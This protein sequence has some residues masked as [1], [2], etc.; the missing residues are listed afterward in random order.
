LL[1]HGVSVL[2]IQKLLGHANLETTAIYLDMS[3]EHLRKAIKHLPDP[4]MHVEGKTVIYHQPMGEVIEGEVT[5]VYTPK[6]GDTRP[7]G[8]VRKRARLEYSLGVLREQK[9]QAA[10]KKKREYIVDYMFANFPT[11]EKLV[12]R[13]GMMKMK[14]DV[15]MKLLHDFSKNIK[16]LGREG[17]AFTINRLRSEWLDLFYEYDAL[18]TSMVKLEKGYPVRD[19]KERPMFAARK[20]TA[21]E[22]KLGI[23][24]SLPKNM[25]TT[26]LG[27]TNMPGMYKSWIL[28]NGDVA[29]V[30]KLGDPLHPVWAHMQ[31]AIMSGANVSKLFKDGLVK[32]NVFQRKG[33]EPISHNFE[34]V[35]QGVNSANLAT[36]KQ[37]MKQFTVEGRINVLTVTV[38]DRSGRIEYSS[39]DQIPKA[40]DQAIAMARKPSKL[41]P[42]INREAAKAWNK[43]IE[44]QN[45]RLKRQREKEDEAKDKD[46]R[47]LIKRLKKEEKKAA[48]AYKRGLIDAKRELVRMVASG[49]EWRKEFANYVQENLPPHVRGKLLKTIAGITS[50][51]TNLKAMGKVLKEIERLE[52]AEAKGR[53]KKW[54]A[55]FGKKYGYRQKQGYKKGMKFKIATPFSAAIE[56]ILDNMMLV[57]PRDPASLQEMLEYVLQEKAMAEEELKAQGREDEVSTHP[58]IRHEIDKSIETFERKLKSQKVAD[59]TA[60]EINQLLELLDTILGEHEYKRSQRAKDVQERRA[61]IKEASLEEVGSGHKKVIPEASTDKDFGK[62]RSRYRTKHFWLGLFGR[63]NYNISTL[64]K[65]MGGM[66]DGALYHTLV[67]QLQRG[68]DDE[69]SHVFM[70]M[71]EFQRLTK[72]AGITKKDL[73]RWSHYGNIRPSVFSRKIEAWLEKNVPGALEGKVEHVE[74]QDFAIQLESG[75]TLRLTVAE[76]LSLLMHVRNEFAYNQLKKNGI[77]TRR[78]PLKRLELKDDDF[79]TV[80]AVMPPKALQ[81]L[82]IMADLMDMQSDAINEVSLELVAGKQGE[83]L[84]PGPIKQTIESRSHLKERKGGTDPIYIDDAFNELVDATRV[85]AEYIGL[86]KPLEDIRWLTNDQDVVKALL[87]RGYGDYYRDYVMQ[88]DSIQEHPIGLDWWE[89]LYGSWVRN[90]TRAVFGLNLRVSAQQY[91]SVML[92]LTE[93]GMGGLKSVRGRFSKEETDRAGRW[94][95]MLRERFMGAITRELG[96]VAQTGGVMRFMTGSDQMVNIPTFLVRLFDKMAVMDVW[97]MAEDEVA[98]REQ[99]AKFDKAQLI[100]EADTLSLAERKALDKKRGSNTARFKNDVTERA[101][102]VVRTTQPTW[103]IVDRSRIGSVKNPVIKGFTMFHSQREK[104]AQMIGIANSKYMNKPQRSSQ[105]RGWHQSIQGRSPD[106]CTCSHQHSVGQGMGHNVR[107]WNAW[108]GG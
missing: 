79:D 17:E 51:E 65:I 104:M 12:S 108:A 105:N 38:G 61:I 88:V 107:S 37:I 49:I 40:L 72:K 57:K 101:E 95:P 25:W 45:E 55:R 21:E 62:G 48:A 1:E 44:K 97:R 66:S 89:K 99:Y 90:I 86:A 82:D 83:K 46:Y 92:A 24:Q 106:I 32:H 33:N 63:F 11:L 54:L 69:K 3:L 58:F 10:L 19:T 71:D 13:E 29:P 94:S 53:L 23:T 96:D 36:M 41:S 47:A 85:A 70:M 30:M 8:G 35:E 102:E 42:A 14:G 9:M 43:H 80:R 75:E 22:K 6:H 67:R 59:M 77:V 103:D 5:E 60:D 2:A 100:K 20:L 73:M 52:K 81:L 34:M 7:G 98:N 87:E 84:Q 56:S 91:A 26:M 31:Q 27:L 15:L 76:G 78:D 28:G 50:K 4:Q 16:D 68:R 39:V 74:T 93:F 64:V 18:Q